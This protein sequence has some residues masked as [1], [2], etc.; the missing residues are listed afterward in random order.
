MIEID[1]GGGSSPHVW[2][3]DLAVVQDCGRIRFIPTRVGNRKPGSVRQASRS[4]HPHT[5][6]EQLSIPPRLLWFVGSSPHVWGTVV[7]EKIDK[8]GYRFIPTRVGNSK[9]PTRGPLF[10]PV[11]PHTC[12]EQPPRAKPPTRMTGSSPHVWGTGKRVHFHPE[13]IRFIPTRVGNRNLVMMP[14]PLL[15]VHPH[16][17]GEQVWYA[18]SPGTGYG[19]SPHVWGTGVKAIPF[20]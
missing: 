8:L 5:C 15:A 20:Q 10:L 4:V 12:G 3:T 13:V 1:S 11:H 2:G 18:V 9:A 6:G 17:C 19:S 14:L 7:D 16:T